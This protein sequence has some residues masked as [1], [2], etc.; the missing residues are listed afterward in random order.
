MSSDL[1][2]ALYERHAR[3]FDQRR[4]RS[5]FERTWLDRFLD[6][7][8]TGGSILDVG[9]GMGEPIARYFLTRGFHVTGVDTS[10]SLVA[11]AR[12]RFATAEWIEGDMR[13]LGLDRKFDGVLAWHSFFHLSAAHQRAMFARFRDHSH[14]GA[15]LMFTSGPDVGA[16]IGCF[17]GEPLFHESLS[18][19][20]YRD[21]LDVNGFA[22]IAQQNEDP[23]CGGAT[24]WLARKQLAP[25]G[26]SRG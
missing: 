2:P 9:C 13:S 18:G 3:A 12:A 24:V 25:P 5:L 8:R 22:V 16:A 26:S 6:Q 10:P 11:L 4:D 7:V 20:E 1:I 21:L 19:D 14:R 23:G 17:E 15:P